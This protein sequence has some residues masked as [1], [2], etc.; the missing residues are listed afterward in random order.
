MAA[1]ETDL[2]IF[3]NNITNYDSNQIY[4]G[5][6]RNN[7]Q[8]N[9]FGRNFIIQ[10]DNNPIQTAKNKLKVVEWPSQSPDLNPIEQHLL[11]RETSKNKQQLKEAVVQVRKSITKKECTSLSMSLS[12]QLNAV[13]GRNGH[14]TKY[15]MLF[16]FGYIKPLSAPILLL[17]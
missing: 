10:Q 6:Y 14:S 5:I 9:L 2:I 3:I 16:T 13:I 15:E 11:K 7:L 4:L 8:R 17:T 1:S 12:C